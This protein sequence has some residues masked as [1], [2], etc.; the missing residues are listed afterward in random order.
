MSP[1]LSPAERQRRR[2]LRQRAAGDPVRVFLL[3][4]VSDA[5]TA[6][7]E[8]EAESFQLRHAQVSEE[9]LWRQRQGGGPGKLAWALIGSELGITDQSA[10]FESWLAKNPKT[11]SIAQRDSGRE[12]DLAT[13]NW[14]ENER[15]AGRATST[16]LTLGLK[17]AKRLQSDEGTPY[18]RHPSYPAWRDAQLAWAVLSLTGIQRPEDASFD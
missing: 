14:V 12:L 13:L 16:V 7:K 8:G 4:V 3:G 9:L 11:G 17:T 1:A 15:R 10:A 18:M 5:E 6:L 2:R